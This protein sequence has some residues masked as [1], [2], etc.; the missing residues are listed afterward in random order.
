MQV[1]GVIDHHALQSST[2]QTK[3]PIFVDI[4][5]WGSMSTIVAHSFVM[6]K[7]P[8]PREVGG[9]LL[10]VTWG[11]YKIGSGPQNTKARSAGSS[12]QVT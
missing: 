1:V 8:M 2:I 3:K 12:L 11:T 9:L 5:P 6:L 4:R 10:Q 7:T